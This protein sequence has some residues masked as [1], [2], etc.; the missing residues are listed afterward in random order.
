MIWANLIGSVTLG[1]VVAAQ[2]PPPTPPASKPKVTVGRP[3]KAD[4]ESPHQ[5]G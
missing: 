1:A 3:A 2:E 4:V 5:S